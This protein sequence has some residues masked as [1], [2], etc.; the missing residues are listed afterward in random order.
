[1][2][3]LVREYDLGLLCSASHPQVSY[4]GSKSKSKRDKIASISG[5]DFK[6]FWGCRPGGGGGASE[7]GDPAAPRGQ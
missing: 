7:K 5:D 4:F 2:P 3:H 6:V 1:M